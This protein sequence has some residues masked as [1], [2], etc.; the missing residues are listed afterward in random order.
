MISTNTDNNKIIWLLG[1]WLPLNIRGELW[2]L[3][4]TQQEKGCMAEKR[5][6]G[7]SKYFLNHPNKSVL[8]VPVEMNQQGDK[9]WNINIFDWSSQISYFWGINWV[10][11]GLFTTKIYSW[12]TKRFVKTF[13]SKQLQSDK[14]SYKEQEPTKKIEKLSFHQC[15]GF[16]GAKNAQ[17]LQS[18]RFPTSAF[19][20]LQ[21]KCF[22][23]EE[24][25]PVSRG[26]HQWLSCSSFYAPEFYT[27]HQTPEPVDTR[28][29]TPARQFFC[30]PDPSTKPSNR[31]YTKS[32]AISAAPDRVYQVFRFEIRCKDF[33]N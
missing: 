26:P 15:H 14:S 5:I 11:I 33:L 9:Q 10:F 22:Q 12:R 30:T 13:W 1:H 17:N 2:S 27:R 8:T 6:G 3:K 20:C 16:F 4:C 29:E 28:H 7:F 25:E 18:E 24:N 32:Y 23:L 19:I 31:P 21:A